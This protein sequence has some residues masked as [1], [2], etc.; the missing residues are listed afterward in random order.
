MFSF[1]FMIYILYLYVGSSSFRAIL[2]TITLVPLTDTKIE[3]NKSYNLSV[4]G[5]VYKYISVV[6]K[7][8]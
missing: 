1:S 7:F 4:S 6:E 2:K 5:N 8:A 3:Q